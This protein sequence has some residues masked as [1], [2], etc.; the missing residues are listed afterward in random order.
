M[1]V[2]TG[3]LLVGLVLIL[4]PT[5]TV[6][7]NGPA[8]M[9]V[10][11]PTWFVIYAIIGQQGTFLAERK[12]FQKL[13]KRPL[14][15]SKRGYSPQAELRQRKREVKIRVDRVP[16]KREVPE[17]KDMEMSWAMKMTTISK[18]QKT[19]QNIQRLGFLPLLWM[20]QNRHP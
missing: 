6:G 15:S 13:H 19:T 12:P 20:N 9:F 17:V 16:S 4:G 14:A 7:Y 18:E 10:A 2:N 11:G 8:S 3:T 5:T 1:Q